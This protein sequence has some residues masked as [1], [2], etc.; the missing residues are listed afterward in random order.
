[1]LSCSPTE[2]PRFSH[3]GCSLL[4]RCTDRPSAFSSN[5]YRTHPD[6]ECVSTQPERCSNRPIV[7]FPF[8]KTVCCQLHVSLCVLLHFAGL[9]LLH[10][11]NRTCCCSFGLCVSSLYPFTSSVNPPTDSLLCVSIGPLVDF[12]L[13]YTLMYVHPINCV[14]RLH[15]YSYDCA[16]VNR[17]P[18][19]YLRGCA[20]LRTPLIDLVVHRL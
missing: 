2:Q 15:N 10:V 17:S 12:P 9:Q 19:N 18:V 14:H 1:M 5:C 3:V 6:A 8:S 7:P 11:V 20:P 4:L 16:L 13:G